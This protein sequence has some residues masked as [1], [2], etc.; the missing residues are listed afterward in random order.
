MAFIPLPFGL[1]AEMKYTIQGEVMV[2]IYH[3]RSEV[4]ILAVNMNA[5][6][7]ILRDA[8]IGNIQALQGADVSLQ[9][10]VVT[11]VSEEDGLQI[12]FADALPDA[13]TATGELLP[14]NVAIVVTNRTD[15]IGRSRRGRTYY[16][17]FT[18]PNVS[19]STPVTAVLT[20]LL[21]FH[22]AVGLSVQGIDMTFGVAS[23]Y[24]NNAPRAEALFT[25]YTQFTADAVTDSQ[26]RRL[27]GRGI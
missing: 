17:G 9:E 8:W 3:F 6:A 1:K 15:F 11:D 18:E 19:G 22:T 25:P 10:I 2:N 23:Y 13:G 24:T 12:T 7:E 21:T 27:P 26:R 5:L 4:A 14:F 20:G 16:G